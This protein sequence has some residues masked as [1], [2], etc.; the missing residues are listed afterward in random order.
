MEKK[1]CNNIDEYIYENTMKVVEAKWS[2][3]IVDA[4]MANKFAEYFEDITIYQLISSEDING[5]SAS[6]YDGVP[7]SNLSYALAYQYDVNGE[8]Q[9]SVD[10]NNNLVFNRK[11]FIEAK[12][13]AVELHKKRLGVDY[14]DAAKSLKQLSSITDGVVDPSLFIKLG[15]VDEERASGFVEIYREDNRQATLILF[16][17]YKNEEKALR[18]KGFGNTVAYSILRYV[19]DGMEERLPYSKRSFKIFRPRFIRHYSLATQLALENMA[20]LSFLVKTGYDIGSFYDDLLKETLRNINAA[21]V[22]DDDTISLF[23]YKFLRE[24]KKYERIRDIESKKYIR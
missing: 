7:S 13:R 19:F 6:C 1:I 14:L 12:K 20:Y 3:G 18:E 22:V 2:G 21:K 16:E 9:Q 24:M 4:A 17:T 10:F 23:E 5:I 15:I 11:N 8:L